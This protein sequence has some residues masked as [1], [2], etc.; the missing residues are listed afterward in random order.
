MFE[1]EIA[2]ERFFVVFEALDIHNE[3]LFSP[4]IIIKKKKNTDVTTG[5]NWRHKSLKF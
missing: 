2:I 4:I 3:N 1:V 5:K